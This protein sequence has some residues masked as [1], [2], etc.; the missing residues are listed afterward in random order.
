MESDVKHALVST[1]L[2]ALTA[3]ACATALQTDPIP[4]ELRHS[5]LQFF[6][7]NHGNDMRGIDRMIAQELRSHGLGAESGFARARPS[8]FDVLVVYEDRWQW[9]MSNYLIFL[10]IDFR[11]P[12]T[13][14]LLATGISYQTSTARKSEPEVVGQIVD[15]M[16]R[17][18]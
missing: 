15:D 11:D 4:T 17:D 7:E 12:S 16:F 3:V 8:E 14:V 6:V 5:S 10:R 13:N 1:I 2:L 18:R 9:D